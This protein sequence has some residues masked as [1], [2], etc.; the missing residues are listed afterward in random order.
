MEPSEVPGSICQ[1]VV[2]WAASVKSDLEYRVYI[3]RLG[4]MV[5]FDLA[6]DCASELMLMSTLK[7]VRMRHL[8]VTMKGTMKSIIRS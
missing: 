4:S 8:L 3:F 1:R 7:R 6:F 5:A 2:Y